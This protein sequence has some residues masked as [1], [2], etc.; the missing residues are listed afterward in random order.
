MEERE[1]KL[2]TD[3]KFEVTDDPLDIWYDGE[4]KMFGTS[5]SK[6][7]DLSVTEDWPEKRNIIV[8]GNRE[9]SIPL[10]CI[11]STKEVICHKQQKRVRLRPGSSSKENKSLTPCIYFCFPF[12]FQEKEMLKR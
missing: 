6:I 10:K 9:F 3:D 1:K 4:P 8:V 7:P 12:T 11:G 2:I 5:V